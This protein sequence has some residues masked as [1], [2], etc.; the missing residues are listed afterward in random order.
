[1]A[2]KWWFDMHLPIQTVPITAEVQ[3]PPME[4]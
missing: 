1:M 3:Y 2:I 4:T